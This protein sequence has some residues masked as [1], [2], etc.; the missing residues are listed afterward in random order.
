MKKT[1]YIIL[2]I[3]LFSSC[4]KRVEKELQS[5]EIESVST[6]NPI[7]RSLREDIFASGVLSTKSE[8]KLAFKTG[9][10]IKK[11]HVKEG[12]LVKK[13]QLLAE[14]DM[15]EINAMV[16][17]TKLGLQKAERDL[18]HVKKMVKDEVATKNKLADATTVFE[19]ANESVQSALF[20]QKLSRI[21]APESGKILIKLVDQGELITPFA[22]ALILSIGGN[23]FNIRVGLAD[24]DIVKLKIGDPAEVLLDA[25]P[26]EVFTARVSEIA[27]MTN[28][29]TGTYE[30]ELILFNKNQRRLI[31]GFVAKAKITPPK[32]SNVLLIPAECLIEAEKTKGFVFVYN[33]NT[34][35]KREVRIGKIFAEEVQVLDGLVVTDKVVSLGSNFLSQGQKV[36]VVNL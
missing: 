14:L 13:G 35:D 22:P 26:D 8:L 24:K 2:L 27:Q 31:S 30:V 11:M 9:G 7:D 28:P 20:N 15:S 1:T 34:V 6:I 36:K 4:K 10:L 19:S 29:K 18:E 16:N 21:Y 3:A 25:Y 12:E 17:Q 23:D 33:G 32:E 5:E